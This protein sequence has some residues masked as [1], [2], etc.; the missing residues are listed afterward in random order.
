LVRVRASLHE[1]VAQKKVAADELAAAAQ[2]RL[3]AQAL[4]AGAMKRMTKLE[5]FAELCIKA[6]EHD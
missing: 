3:K 6:P 4:S 1:T 5:R 2:Q